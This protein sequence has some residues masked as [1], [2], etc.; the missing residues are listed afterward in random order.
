MS[1]KY[2]LSVCAIMKNEA[3][4]L[5]EWLEFHKL[6]GVEKFYLYDNGSTDNTFDI[7]DYYV[8]SGDVVFHNW[9]TVPGQM[10]AYDHCLQT[11]RAA[12]EW[13]AFIDL[14]EFLFCTEK[15][16]LRDILD[17]FAEFPGVGVNWLC[18]GSSGHKTRPEGL[19]IANFTRRAEDEFGPNKLVKSIIRPEQAI[20]PASPHSFLCT[21]NS[22]AVTENK[23]PVIDVS[24]RHSVKKLRINHYVTRSEEEGQQKIMRARADTN[25]FKDT[26]FLEAHNRNEIEDLTIQ[27]FVP[28][29]LKRVQVKQSQLRLHQIKIKLEQSYSR[30]DKIITELDHLPSQ[31]Q[32]IQQKLSEKLPCQSD[33]QTQTLICKESEQPDLEEVW[34][35]LSLEHSVKTD[36]LIKEN[37][38]RFPSR[39]I[40]FINQVPNLEL[41]TIANPNLEVSIVIPVF[42]K[43]EYTRHCLASLFHYAH[44]DINFEVIVVNNASSDGTAEY[45]RE[46][47]PE[48]NL[49]SNPHN[50]GFAKACNQGALLSRAPYI[51][52]LN[53]D[54]YFFDDTW[55]KEMLS[56]IQNKPDV[57][58]VGNRQLFPHDHTI[59][60]AGIV[61]KEDKLPVHIFPFLPKDYPKALIS[62]YI[63]AVTGAC[64]LVKRSLF[65]DIGMFDENYVNGYEDVDLCLKASLFN[66]KTWYSASSCI[67]HFGFIS[68]GRTAKDHLNVR[69]FTE[70]W[71]DRI[72]PNESLYS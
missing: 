36:N 47:Y 64:V 14:D 70:K 33:D 8:Q 25:Q 51:L 13:M 30:M 52:F 37:I 12:S 10:S 65:Y 34:D 20:R 44:K 58:I 38:L 32:Q 68:E 9:P 62:R 48:I 11:Y 15:T 60:H 56:D 5:I 49:V 45:I 40:R 53:N 67:Y 43:I 4:Y 46:T 69:Y 19:Q 23:E 31:R 24:E 7:V 18:F 59:H 6:V 50:L 21:N 17:E 28:Q 71:S 55:L 22:L 42:N 61:F 3:P 16:N 72:S 35:Q 2:K 63:P 66:Q 54:T 27:R 41:T 1:K 29:L 57:G 26:S 39:F